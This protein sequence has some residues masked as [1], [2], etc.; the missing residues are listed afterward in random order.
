MHLTSLVPIPL[1]LIVLIVMMKLFRWMS[2]RRRFVIMSVLIACRSLVLRTFALKN[3]L[4]VYVRKTLFVLL[5][6]LPWGTLYSYKCNVLPLMLFPL[7]RRRS[8]RKRP[9]SVLL[10][11]VNYR[12][13]DGC[14]SYRKNPLR[15]TNEVTKDTSL[16]TTIYK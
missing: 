14:Q 7:L 8:C 2:L 12:T 9:K 1:R 6:T 13:V 16:E 3:L 11:Y 10:L 5:I 15:P 4:V